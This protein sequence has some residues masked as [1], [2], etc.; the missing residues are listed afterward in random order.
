MDA[1]VEK[2]NLIDHLVEITAINFFEL[3]WLK[4]QNG[5]GLCPRKRC[6]WA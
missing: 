5:D 4:Q 2:F 6:L 3:L 1:F